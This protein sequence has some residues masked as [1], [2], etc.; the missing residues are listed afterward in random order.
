[1]LLKDK[2]INYIEDDLNNRAVVQTIQEQHG[3]KFA[4]ER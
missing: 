1:M 2:R 4:C 3:A